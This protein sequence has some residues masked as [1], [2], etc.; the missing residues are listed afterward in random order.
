[1]KVNLKDLRI[2]YINLKDYPNRN[3]SMDNMLRH[4][5]L[6]YYRVEGVSG[7]YTVPH[8]HLKALETNP[9]I[10]L[11]DDC[12]PHFYREEIE[13]PDDADV[14]F[15][16]VSTGTTKTHIPKYKKISE[17][18]Y[19]LYDMTTLHAILYVTDRG[20]EWLR[21]A[22]QLSVEENIGMDKATAQTLTAINAYGLNYPIWYQ[23][24]LVSQTKITLDEG[25]LSDEYWGGG[26]DDYPEPMSFD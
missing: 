19:R 20:R 3:K 25:L 12:I 17:D 26:F 4:Q 13:F 22:Y 11:E 8:S 5:G 9:D 18:I 15:L 6:N 14:L 2:A 16:G 23:K 7:G 1:M 21:N 10:I 24:D